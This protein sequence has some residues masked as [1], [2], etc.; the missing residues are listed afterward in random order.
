MRG[1]RC[2]IYMMSVS[3][4]PPTAV[5]SSRVG[6]LCDGQVCAGTVPH[7]R[8]EPATVTHRNR[9]TPGSCSLLVYPRQDVCAGGAVSRPGLWLKWLLGHPTERHG[10]LRRIGAGPCRAIDARWP[11]AHLRPVCLAMHWHALEPELHPRSRGPFVALRS[12]PEHV[13]GTWGRWRAA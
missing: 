10:H 3:W 11:C 8:A 12:L 7:L 6:R 9:Y 5:Q 1:V 4:A 2:E 13:D